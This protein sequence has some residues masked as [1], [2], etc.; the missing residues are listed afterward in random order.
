MLNT[1]TL[2]NREMVFSLRSFVSLC[3]YQPADK[4]GCHGVLTL[5]SMTNGENDY[6]LLD[7]K[8]FAG[9]FQRLMEHPS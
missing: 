6:Y 3:E 5:T 1:T 2:D 7:Q 8:Q 9:L 4:P